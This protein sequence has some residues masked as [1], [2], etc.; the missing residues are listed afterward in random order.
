MFVFQLTKW[1][2]A[3]VLVATLVFTMTEN[4]DAQET[5]TTS[6]G[7]RYIETAVGSGDVAKSGDNVDVHYTGWLY[8]DG[9]KGNKFDSSVDR[10]QTFS[11]PLGAGRVI[12]GWD[13]GVSGMQPGGKR[14][15][16][17]PPALGYGA[18]GAGGVIPPNA[19][20]MFDVELI[21]IK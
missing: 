10:G 21:G 16:I 18:S 9:E 13:E 1:M 20:L 2:S 17:I 19:T 5:I 8:N 14:T 11:F 3:A 6:S 15:L 7:L 12:G 4:S